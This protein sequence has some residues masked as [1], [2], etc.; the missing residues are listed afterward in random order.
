M[1]KGEITLKKQNIAVLIILGVLVLGAIWYT[2]YKSLDSNKET[3]ALSKKE[4]SKVVNPSNAKKEPGDENE[5]IGI[6]V[7]QKAPDFKLKTLDGQTVELSQSN[8]LTIVN[9]W[10]TW[11]P[12][13]R[14]EMPEFQKAYEKYKDKVN[15]MMINVTSTETDSSAVPEFVKKNGYTFPVLLDDGSVTSVPV[16]DQ[17]GI[18]AIPTTYI[19]DATG[20]IVYKR[21]GMMNM[22][23]L[24]QWISKFSK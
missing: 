8:K 18:V 16:A 4:Q 2:F 12:P 15:F 13:C 11:C 9:F 17:Y 21:S 3:A 6:K 5:A 1:E 19:V 14:E 10:A 20:K 24:E 23:D 7:G 22:K